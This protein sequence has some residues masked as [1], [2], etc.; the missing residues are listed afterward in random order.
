MGCRP[1]TLEQNNNHISDIVDKPS[2]PSSNSDVNT[3][4]KIERLEEILVHFKSSEYIFKKVIDNVM[5]FDIEKIKEISKQTNGPQI[6]SGSHCYVFSVDNCAETINLLAKINRYK[7]ICKTEKIDMDYSIKTTEFKTTVTFAECDFMQLLFCSL[8]IFDI[9]GQTHLKSYVKNIACLQSEIKRIFADFDIGKTKLAD[10]LLFENLTDDF[11]TVSKVLNSS[12]CICCQ[13]NKRSIVLV[14]C[15]HL[16]YCE[17]CGISSK[18]NTCPLC[19]TAIL[20]KIVVL[21]C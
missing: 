6:F 14:P 3:E 18:V 21:D 13:E 10:K 12:Y 20:D 15:R 17:S 2:A 1:S 4:D 5:N 11:L 9:F 8:V 16:T 7:P 19:R